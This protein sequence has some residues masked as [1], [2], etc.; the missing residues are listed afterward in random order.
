[1]ACPY[2]YAVPNRSSVRRH[3][4]VWA[5]LS[6]FLGSLAVL[7]A[8]AA[9][10]SML[11]QDVR[12]GR[13]GGTCSVN[14]VA[15]I[16]IGADPHEAAQG[17]THCDLCASLDWALPP[18]AVVAIPSFAGQQAAMVDF[19]A[20]LAVTIPGLPFSRGPPALLI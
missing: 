1:M 7:A 20:A 17:A 14:A 18:L 3:L 6:A 2:N 13:L 12:T 16:S 4:T 5:R 9:P 15:G 19:P 8:L 11:T 10:L